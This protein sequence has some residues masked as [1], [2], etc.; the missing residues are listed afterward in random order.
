MLNN[1]FYSEYANMVNFYRG[2]SV[3]N[4]RS[5]YLKQLQSKYKTKIGSRKISD[6]DISNIKECVDS[7]SRAVESIDV[8]KESTEA[9][10]QS[11]KSK[12]REV[13]WNSQKEIDNFKEQLNTFFNGVD[14]NNNSAEK[15]IS[16][17]LKRNNI[18]ISGGSNSEI[19][20]T[21]EQLSNLN[22]FYSKFFND[23]PA[24]KRALSNIFTMLP[25]LQQPK[26]MWE[27]DSWQ[28]MSKSLSSYLEGAIGSYFDEVL[29]KFEK[30]LSK[31]RTLQD[32]IELGGKGGKGPSLE[33]QLVSS[34]ASDPKNSTKKMRA[35]DLSDY[36]VRS[37]P[38][39]ITKTV[40]MSD[41]Y[42]SWNMS[43][44]TSMT[45]ERSKIIM[46]ADA[47]EFLNIRDNNIALGNQSINN[48][49]FN[50]SKGV[51]LDAIMTSLKNTMYFN[52]DKIFGNEISFLVGG[53]KY[54]SGDA[55]LEQMF[56]PQDLI[57]RLALSNNGLGMSVFS[58][59]KI[60]IRGYFAA[61]GGK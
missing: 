25:N 8:N 54:T 12:K 27:Y 43:G 44:R 36:A 58:S 29:E 22:D 6:A 40:S 38:G 45:T 34:S 49:L 19:K 18:K 56:S 2:R 33:V 35:M 46:M 50:E 10:K 9:F 60:E 47:N 17:F 23:L 39:I 61:E 37:K 53:M 20:I 57:E 13:K 31:G 24:A 30:K 15:E 26:S 1:S 48:D 14:F 42:S 55:M 28:K 21:E 51:T 16:N 4:N 59:E 5:A 3:T 41:I 32:L 7:I 52:A 11:L